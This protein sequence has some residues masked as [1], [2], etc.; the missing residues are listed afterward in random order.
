MSKIVRVCTAHASAHQ[1]EQRE[2]DVHSSIIYLLAHTHKHNDHETTTRSFL[3]E[4]LRLLLRGS[5][6]SA[7]AVA[8]SDRTARKGVRDNI[9][10]GD[11]RKCAHVE[12]DM[13]YGTRA[14]LRAHRIY[15]TWN[16]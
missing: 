16:A 2:K 5:A 9:S 14:V 10:V 15:F 8:R 12:W 6:S 3:A 1:S 11:M 7:C 13:G 4:S